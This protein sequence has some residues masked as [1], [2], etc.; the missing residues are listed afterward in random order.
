EAGQALD[1]LQQDGQ[2]RFDALVVLARQLVD[3]E[4]FSVAAGLFDRDEV[5]SPLPPAALVPAVNAWYQVS[6]YQKVVD[7]VS[8]IGSV[9][10]VDAW[11]DDDL[12]AV[13]IADSFRL[14]QRQQEALAWVDGALAREGDRSPWLYYVRGNIGLETGDRAGAEADARSMLAGLPDS[15]DGRR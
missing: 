11:G 9:G 6:S 8:H 3:A 13:Y 4:Q 14:L 15:P 1:L 2:D 7:A 10:D 12:A 5:P